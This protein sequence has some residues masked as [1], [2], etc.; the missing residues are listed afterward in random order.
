MTHTSRLFCG[1]LIALASSGCTVVADLDGYISA[2]DIG[3]D[4]QMTVRDFTPHLT[5]AVF[6]QAVTRDDAQNLRALAV[7][8]PLADADR[9][10]TMPNAIG[11]G[12]HAFNFWADENDDR[13]VQTSPF[14]GPDHSWRLDDVCNWASTCSGVDADLANCFSHV[15]P[16]D[17]IT[18]PAEPGNSLVLNLTAIP[19]TAGFVEVHLIEVDDAAQVRRVV[20]LYRRDVL[21]NAGEE[22]PRCTGDAIDMEISCTFTL[23]GLAVAGRRYSADIIIDLDG[24]GEI[25]GATEVFSITESDGSAYANPVDLDVS[26]FDPAG[27]LPE[28]GVLVS[29]LPGS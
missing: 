5:D 24:N 2:D 17:A 18:D 16:F 21:V 22:E 27:A 23:A 25:G 7:I 20:G 9:S 13:S 15:A 4:M 26:T 29:P 6:F 11:D 8:D 3:C 19:L 12:A 28:E 14:N 10:F 1:A